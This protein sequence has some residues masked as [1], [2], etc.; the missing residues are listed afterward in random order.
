MPS[1]QSF[2]LILRNR[3][4]YKLLSEGMPDLKGE[5]KMSSNGTNIGNVSKEDQVMLIIAQL[6]E[7]GQD[8]ENTC[9]TL[10]SLTKIL[11][12]EYDSPRPGQQ[13]PKPLHEL[14]DSDSFDTILGFLDMREGPT[15][16]G[17][18]TLTVSTFLKASDQKGTEYL[19]VFF[20]S[21]VSKGTYNDFIIAFSVAACIFPIVPSVS[22]DLFLSNGFVNGL[23]P[24]MRRKWKSKKVEQACLEMLNA[25]CMNTACR[26]AIQKYCTEWLEEIVARQVQDVGEGRQA[27]GSDGSQ[28]QGV[29]S[30]IVRNFAAVILAKLQ[31]SPQALYR[32]S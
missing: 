13:V 15:V 20:K 1:S 23:G 18:A 9:R 11:S 5:S 6:M 4:E 29:H 19:T 22:A 24:L 8:D 10:D 16:R 14:I 30:E 28:Q 2:L 21:R 12:D 17:H 3:N 7:G 27:G 32:S 26:E 25:A 31:V